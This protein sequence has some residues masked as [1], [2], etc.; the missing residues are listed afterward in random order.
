MSVARAEATWR[1]NAACQGSSANLFYP[2]SNIEAR[3]TR[4]R[5]EGAARALC[6]ACSVREACLEYALYVQEP[7]GIWGG[8]TEVERRRL[9]RRSSVG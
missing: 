8:L 4:M 2:P 5:R 7:H 6:Q 9:I 1:A 3:E